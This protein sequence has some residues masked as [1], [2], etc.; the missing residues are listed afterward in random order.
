M[1]SDLSEEAG[2]EAEKKILRINPLPDALFAANDTCAVSCMIALKNS[3]IKIPQ[4]I[5][6]VGFNNDIVPRIVK[7]NMT[8]INIRQVKWGK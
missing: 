5:T 6:I 1:I 8:T 3:N 2:V 4:D 7:P